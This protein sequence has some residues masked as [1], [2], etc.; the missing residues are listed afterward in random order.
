MLTS[1]MYVE[2]K[3]PKERMRATSCNAHNEM[4]DTKGFWVGQSR[5]ELDLCNDTRS[6]LVIEEWTQW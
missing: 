6:F 3:V 4:N 1:F 2:V 5:G